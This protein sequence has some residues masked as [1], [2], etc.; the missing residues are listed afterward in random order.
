MITSNS[1]HGKASGKSYMMPAHKQTHAHMHAHTHTHTHACTH[2]HARTHT[3]AHTHTHIH[4][5]VAVIMCKSIRK[6]WWKREVF[7]LIGF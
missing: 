3:H 6:V 7:S 1:S 4:R 2:T 5:Q